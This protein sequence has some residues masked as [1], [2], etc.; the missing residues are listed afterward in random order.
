MNHH[1]KNLCAL[2]GYVSTIVCI[3]ACPW[4][5]KWLLASYIVY[6]VAIWLGDDDNE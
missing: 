2:C 3:T 6:L 5:V 1:V 4:L